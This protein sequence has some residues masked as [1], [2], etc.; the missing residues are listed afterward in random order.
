MAVPETTGAEESKGFSISQFLSETKVELKKVTW[1]TKQ[2][3]I[4]N[5]IVVLIAVCLCAGLIWVI[6]SIFSVLFGMILR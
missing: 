6:D 4:A 3:L 5:T 1:P 2:E